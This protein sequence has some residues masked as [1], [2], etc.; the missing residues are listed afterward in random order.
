MRYGCGR[1]TQKVHG[2]LETSLHFFATFFGQV[3]MIEKAM[4]DIHFSAHPTRSAKQQVSEPQKSIIG[5][6]RRVSKR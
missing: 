6:I 5:C 1:S 4:R 3:S 2:R